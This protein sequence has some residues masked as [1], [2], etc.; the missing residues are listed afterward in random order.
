MHNSLYS[1]FYHRPA[2]DKCEAKGA[3]ERVSALQSTGF[4]SPLDQPKLSLMLR[5]LSYK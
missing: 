5:Q 4:I 1:L 2:G 3:A